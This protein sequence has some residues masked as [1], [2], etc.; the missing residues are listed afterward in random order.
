MSMY[1]NGEYDNERAVVNGGAHGKSSDSAVNAER[2]RVHYYSANAVVVAV[3]VHVNA[4]M[5]R[6]IAVQMVP[7][8][9]PMSN[10]ERKWASN[11]PT[12][13]DPS[14]MVQAYTTIEINC[15]PH[16]I[17]R[18]PIIIRRNC[19][20]THQPSLLPSAIPSAF[21][22]QWPTGMSVYQQSAGI[23]SEEPS[24]QMPTGM[25]TVYQFSHWPKGIQ[26][27]TTHIC[28]SS[29]SSATTTTNVERINL[30]GVRVF[31]LAVSKNMLTCKM[32]SDSY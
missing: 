12:V 11:V 21:P 29:S 7:R 8:V 28:M 5:Y 30:R 15:T 17:E 22:T 2:V 20:M 19:M 9:V 6:N 18:Q 13:I 1:I 3:N 31:Y 14:I 26:I 27:V 32:A 24:S 10:V 16:P 4:H 23:P 25:Q